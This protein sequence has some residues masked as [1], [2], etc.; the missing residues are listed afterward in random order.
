MMLLK[1]FVQ[2][3]AARAF[4]ESMKMH[5]G[6]ILFGKSWAVNFAQ[7]AHPRPAA[8]VANLSASITPTMI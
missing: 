5:V 1:V 7:T 3:L 6:A 8:L 4:K 2:R